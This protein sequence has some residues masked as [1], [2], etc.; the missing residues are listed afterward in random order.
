MYVHYTVNSLAFCIDSGGVSPSGP[1]CQI[2]VEGFGDVWLRK[3]K[4]KLPWSS[5]SSK[6]MPREW[7]L[8]EHGSSWV[9]LS[10]I[11]IIAY[12]L[13]IMHLN[14]L[15]GYAH[16]LDQSYIRLRFSYKSQNDVRRLSVT[17]HESTSLLRSIYQL[18]FNILCFIKCH[19]VIFSI[20]INQGIYSKWK[21]AINIFIKRASEN[22]FVKKNC[23]TKPKWQWLLTYCPYTFSKQLMWY[24]HG[25]FL[26]HTI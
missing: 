24:F 22:F 17:N 13:V 10:Y 11:P 19:E 18:K 7:L 2:R 4:I 23:Y 14:D 9:L 21:S 6:Y 20:Y 26:W 15:I 16:D 5:H 12:T 8:K 25:W 1:A 3:Q